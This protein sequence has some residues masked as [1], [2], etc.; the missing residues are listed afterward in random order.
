MNFGKSMSES[1]VPPKKIK[2]LN[3]VIV[4]GNSLFVFSE[5]NRLRLA[6]ANLVENPYFENFI[7][8]LIFLNAIFLMIEEPIL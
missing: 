7:F 1:S 3:Q 4:E 6:I 5:K 8:H 2:R